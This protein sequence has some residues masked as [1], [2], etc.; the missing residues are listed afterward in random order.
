MFNFIG[1]LFARRQSE[2]PKHEPGHVLY[3]PARSEAGVVVTEDAALSCGPAFACGALIARSIAMLPAH[4]MVPI[5]GG[6][7]SQAL[8]DHPVADLMHRAPN[9]EISAFQLREMLLLSAIFKG[10]AYAEIEVDEFG[11]PQKLWP[12]HPDRVE[13]C[14][15][16][17]GRLVY[18][19]D[20]GAGEKVDIPAANMFHLA[21]PSLCGPIGMSLISRA[22]H[23]L[24]LAISQERFAAN[25]IRN[26][27]APSGIVKVKNNISADGLKLVRAEVEN[28][29]KGPR[30]AGK[31]MIG[32][33]DWS[34]EQIGVSPQ[35]AEFLAQRKFAVEEICRWFGVPPQMVG[36][37]DK[38]TLNNYEQAGLQ[39]LTLAVLPWVVKFEQEANRKLLTQ[40]SARGRPYL[41]INTAAIVRANIEAQSRA[42]AMGRQW[43]WLSVNDIRRLID[44]EPIGPEGDVYLQ[45]M[46][47]EPL[48]D[49]AASRDGDGSGDNTRARLLQFG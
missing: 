43:G 9:E 12:I 4:V 16:E 3:F 13:V 22:R 47:M 42:F 11:R 45:P 14:R 6:D 41:K 27:A 28:L 20:N 29:Y 1:R 36:V 38:Q 49:T 18:E 44:M 32:D 39:F 19:V 17:S 24:G 8:P 15:D 35:D 23:T 2:P 5:A 7:G 33:Q 46:N 26:A 34:W 21:G 31:I 25:F 10:N 48:G 40:R 30:K 37:Q